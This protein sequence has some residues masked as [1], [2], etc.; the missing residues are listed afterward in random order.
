MHM[1][2]LKLGMPIRGKKNEVK[3]Q[4][5]SGW[6]FSFHITISSYNCIIQIEKISPT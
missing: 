2:I 3:C 4:Q 1:G 6:P 5:M